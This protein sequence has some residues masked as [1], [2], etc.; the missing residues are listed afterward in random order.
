MTGHAGANGFVTWILHVPAG[1]TG[2]D[3]LHAFDFI[4]DGLQTPETAAS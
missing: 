3:R 4:E 1:V 2:F